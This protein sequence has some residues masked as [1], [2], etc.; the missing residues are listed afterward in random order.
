V[1]NASTKLVV[2]RA[3]AR[4]KR[5]ALQQ[6]ALGSLWPVLM[7][8]WGM[9]TLLLVFFV[10]NALI[11]FFVLRRWWRLRRTGGAVTALLDDPTKIREIAT[12]P[13]KLPPNRLPVFVD[14]FTTNGARCSLLLDPKKPEE[15]ANL[16]GALHSRSPDA[17]LLIPKLPATPL[18]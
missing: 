11:G 14:I 10:T 13:R 8:M 3:I 12:W 9:S 7:L 5:N 15:V 16:L 18:A 1:T 6:L 17:L 2:E 4:T